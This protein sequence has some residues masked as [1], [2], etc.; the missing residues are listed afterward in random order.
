[1]F[2]DSASNSQDLSAT[3]ILARRAEKLAMRRIWL[4]KLIY[5]A[6]PWFYLAAGCAAFMATIYIS[7]WFWVLPH[8]LLF[9]AGCLHLSYAVYRRRRRAARE[10]TNS[11]ESRPQDAHRFP[12]AQTD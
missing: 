3:Q 2:S 10:R 8:Y 5:D 9:A 11:Q 6:L 7:E 12:V 1:M 4:P